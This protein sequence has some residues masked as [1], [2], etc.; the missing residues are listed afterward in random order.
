MPEEIVFI[1]VVS[2]VSLT[3]LG[4]GLMRTIGKHLERKWQVTH[5]GAGAEQVSAEMEELRV[6]LEGADELRE[7][8][9]D[10][11]ER[12]DFAER[13]LAEGR[14]PNQLRSQP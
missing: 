12:M 7:R 1:T 4:F 9:A 6:R 14:R 8:V 10:L 13:V 3:A 5:G 2:I 11:E